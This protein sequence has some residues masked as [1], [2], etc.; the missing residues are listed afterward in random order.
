M[1]KQFETIEEANQFIAKANKLLGYP[2]KYSGT[3][4]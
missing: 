3:E 1:T 4:T 2:D